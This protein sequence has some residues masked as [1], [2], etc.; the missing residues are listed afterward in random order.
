VQI[1]SDSSSRLLA[2]PPRLQFKLEPDFHLLSRPASHRLLRKAY[3]RCLSFVCE[4]STVYSSAYSDE[5]ATPGGRG[6]LI[7]L[8][9]KEWSG[10]VD[11][12]HRPPGP[13]PDSKPY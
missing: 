1:S 3:C 9:T 11:L 12:N 6:Y 13:E 2:S 8:K 10:R 4:V 7:E 5:N